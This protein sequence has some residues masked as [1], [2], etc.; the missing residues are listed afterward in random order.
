MDVIYISRFYRESGKQKPSYWHSVGNK[1]LCALTLGQLADM[2]A[3]RWADQE[4]V[5]SLYQGRNFT[6]RQLRDKVMTTVIRVIIGLLYKSVVL[7]HYWG[8][9]GDIHGLIPI[10][11]KRQ[12]IMCAENSATILRIINRVS[13]DKQT[14]IFRSYFCIKLLLLSFYAQWPWGRLNF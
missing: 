11:K 7:C 14:G 5:M 6:F 8:C 4:A 10:S 12:M 9:S 3:E 2:A 13:D 1:P